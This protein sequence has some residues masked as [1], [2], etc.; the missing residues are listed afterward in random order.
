MY[1]DRAV[2]IKGRCQTSADV[3]V[4][5]VLDLD[6]DVR[7]VQIESANAS[8]TAFVFTTNVPKEAIANAVWVANLK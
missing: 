3:F 1:A 7:Y 4:D 2:A 6:N 5:I 8:E